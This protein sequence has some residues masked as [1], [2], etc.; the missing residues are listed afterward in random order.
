MEDY[1]FLIGR[2]VS[3]YSM[4][5][6]LP[7]AYTIQ[8]V[9]MTP[10][11]F[12]NRDLIISFDNGTEERIPL[13]KV[14]S[15]IK[16]DEVVLRTSKGESYALQLMQGQ[17]KRKMAKGGNLEP[18]SF[19][20]L[21][22]MLEMQNSYK[23]GKGG[24]TQSADGHT[25]SFSEYLS[26]EEEVRWHLKGIKLSKQDVVDFMSLSKNSEHKYFVRGKSW[27]S[28]WIFRGELRLND[29]VNGIF[30]TSLTSPKVLP[31]DGEYY[32][33]EEK[34]TDKERAF[35]PDK[36]KFAIESIHKKFS[37]VYDIE[38]SDKNKLVA[39]QVR[40]QREPYAKYDYLPT[41]EEAYAKFKRSLTKDELDSIE[42]SFKK[43]EF[44]DVEEHDTDIYYRE[45]T[46]RRKNLSLGGALMMAEGAKRIAPK[47]M[48]A[49]D[50][51]MAQRAKRKSFW[52]R[53][54]ETG[55]EPQ[56]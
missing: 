8:M 32:I 25:K 51:R 12:D 39:Y 15:F 35:D 53:M 36:Y 20:E 34:V 16:G 11:K 49:M 45:I 48:D 52:E 44:A 50:E 46:V 38:T 9:R 10:A 55:N 42:I 19:E 54:N 43:E 21:E 1:S 6:K 17:S 27:D 13:S 14:D 28:Y 31:D 29:S 23:F 47:T 5:V 56:S 40:Y 4:G 30:L 18:V 3:L 37:D 22:R 33:W 2:W 41:W 24:S 7:T 26:N